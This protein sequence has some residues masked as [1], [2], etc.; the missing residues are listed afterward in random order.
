[1]FILRKPQARKQSTT[2]LRHM[3]NKRATSQWPA[4]RVC[5]SLS[6][7]SSLLS[8]RRSKGMYLANVL[9]SSRKRGTAIRKWKDHKLSMSQ[10]VGV[11][12]HE[13]D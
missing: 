10:S 8:Q 1:M 9:C 13:S 4:T 5:Q 6:R 3:A 7:D 12:L 11:G 2:N